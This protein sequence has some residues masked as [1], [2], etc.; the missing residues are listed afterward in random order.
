[1]SSRLLNSSEKQ[2]KKPRNDVIDEDHGDHSGVGILNNVF[3]GKRIVDAFLFRSNIPVEL[4]MIVK[5]YLL[6]QMTN[7]TIRQAVDLWISDRV[8][9]MRM[10]G[11]I[12][13]WNTSQVTNMDRLFYAHKRAYLILMIGM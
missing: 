6:P 4:R 13:D 7:E 10:Y 8:K 11:H 2:A 9:A 3:S 5:S 12:S 1:M